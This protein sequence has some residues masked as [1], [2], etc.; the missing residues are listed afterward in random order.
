MQYKS[1]IRASPKKFVIYLKFRAEGA[2]RNLN[3]GEINISLKIAQGKLWLL[4]LSQSAQSFKTFKKK[5]KYVLSNEIRVQKIYNFE[6]LI[7]H[8]AYLKNIAKHRNIRKR[9]FWSIF[10]SKFARPKL[11][12]S[13]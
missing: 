3:I 4:P 1:I 12:K 13:F 5:Y 11:L 6:I 10:G 2:L 7:T 8:L 9:P